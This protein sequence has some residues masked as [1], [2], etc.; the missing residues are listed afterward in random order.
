MSSLKVQPLTSQN[1]P[2]VRQLV[3]DAHVRAV[4]AIFN[5]IKLRPIAL[6]V[7]TAISTA[8]LKFRQ[9][10]IYNY[11][12]VLTILAG[13]IIVTQGLLFLV[14]LYD[15]S[16]QA[17]GSEVVG[18]LQFF[19]DQD[20]KE[21]TQGSSSSKA[22]T[23]KTGVEK[24]S[25]ATASSKDGD[26]NDSSKNKIP[27]SKSDIVPVTVFNK[28]NQ[29]WVLEKDDQGPIGCIGATVDRGTGL[30]KLTVWTVAENTRRK[31]VGS[32]LLKTAMDQLCKNNKMVKVQVTLQ[33][34]QIPALRLFFKF[35]FLQVDRVPEW[36][37][38]RVVLEMSTK[39]WIKNQQPA[40]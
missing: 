13:S 15:A 36:M 34:H 20:L 19:A 22:S 1:R 6:V 4:P 3:F 37:G 33:G 9:T 8:I 25:A 29:F 30:A 18:K 23:N 21:E 12:E 38:E 35:G 39:D 27:I 5:F 16:T 2:G 10:S 11:N 14:L 40:K 7:W 32:V 24:R 28:D 31:G 26:S 17:P